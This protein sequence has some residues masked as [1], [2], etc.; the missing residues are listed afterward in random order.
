[1]FN[2]AENKYKENIVCPEHIICAIPIQ[3]EEY[4]LCPA[5]HRQSVKNQLQT[6]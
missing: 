4:M 6:S 5:Q 3:T 2:I 1:M